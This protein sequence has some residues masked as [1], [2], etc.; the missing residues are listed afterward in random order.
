MK[1]ALQIRPLNRVMD[2]HERLCR[3]G[4]SHVDFLRP[5]EKINLVKLPGGASRLF[6]LSLSEVTGLLGR[7]VLTKMWKPDEILRSAE[8]TSSHLTG[9]GMS[10]IFYDDPGYPRRLA[11][12]YDPPLVLFIRGS[13][14]DKNETLVGIVGTRFPTG[15]GR[16][17]AF[18]LGFDFGRNGFWVVS[19]LARGIDRE[20]HEGCEQAGGRSIAVLGNGI[21]LVYPSSSRAAA[22][23]LL[24]RGG[25]I[26]SEYPPGIPP[27]RYHFP[28][29]NRIISGLCRGVVVVEAPERSGALF[30]AD[31]ALQ[32]H[33]DLW[34]HAAGVNGTVGAGTRHLAE[35]GAPTVHGAADIMKEWGVAPRAA[36]PSAYDKLP[37]GQ[38]LAMVTKEE[39]S[40]ACVQR[41]GE[42]YWRT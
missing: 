4:L 36:T 34:V 25:A 39:I 5:R 42:T 22:L 23:A 31:Y 10:S 27:L 26:V 29:R 21:D 41:A 20:A 32:E 7:R 8:A 16:A 2:D 1:A 14:P 35:S 3:L 19:G 9:E 28:A 33:R 17:A 18:R 38:R 12:I 37:E 30:T 15:A 6:D 13:L 24:A 40:G 11:G